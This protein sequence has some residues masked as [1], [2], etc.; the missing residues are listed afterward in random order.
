MNK[1][2]SQ[3][4]FA[5]LA[6]VIL[7]AVAL[8]GTLGFVFW[9]NFMQPKTSDVKVDTSTNTIPKSTTQTTT[10]VVEVDPTADWNE[11]SRDGIMLKY[12]KSWYIYSSDCCNPYFHSVYF[13]N[14]QYLEGLDN[15]QSGFVGLL[16]GYSMNGDNLGSFTG[17]AKDETYLS[18]SMDLTYFLKL[19]HGMYGIDTTQETMQIGG[20]DAI[21]LVWKGAGREGV[22]MITPWGVK[23]SGGVFQFD[24]R[25]ASDVDSSEAEKSV[26]QILDTVEFTNL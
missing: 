11:Y 19:G 9:Q 14:K 1:Q 20:V 15:P 2:K 23:T 25:I 16:L 12:P 18:S 24:Y 7:L 17:E 6:I 5:H 13:S 26:N 8:A 22:D 21:R 3:S 4:G 10:P